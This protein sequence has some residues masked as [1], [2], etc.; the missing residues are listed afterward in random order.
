VHCPEAEVCQPI[1]VT[2]LP[3]GRK[4]LIM[5]GCGSRGDQYPPGEVAR[6]DGGA[7]DRF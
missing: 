3:F 2:P 6:R 7:T 4:S 1:K 5:D